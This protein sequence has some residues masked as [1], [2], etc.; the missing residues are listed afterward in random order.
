MVTIP[1]KKYIR[2]LKIINIDNYLKKTQ[3]NIGKL[4]ESYGFKNYSTFYR[5]YLSFIGKSPLK[6]K[7]K[8]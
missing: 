7:S 6:G 1:E 2:I 3:N 4:V 5:N 8:H